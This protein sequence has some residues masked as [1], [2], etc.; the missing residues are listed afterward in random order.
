MQALNL[1]NPLIWVNTFCLALVIPRD[2]PPHHWLEPLSAADLQKWP[3][4]AHVADF[5]KIFQRLTNHK[6]ETSGLGV[7]GTLAAAQGLALVAAGLD[8][9]LAFSTST[10]GNHLQVTL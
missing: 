7:P 5:P 8:L 9:H 10:S 1:N 6:Q 3:A 4:S 2:H